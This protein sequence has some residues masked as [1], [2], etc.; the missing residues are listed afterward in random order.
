MTLPEVAP[1]GTGVTMLV[2]AHVVGVASEPLK[3][4]VLLPCG[5][6]KFDPE[7]VSEFPIAP[8]LGEMA[9]ILGDGT[10]VKLMPLLAT[11]LAF[12][13]TFPVVAPAGTTATTLVAIQ[14]LIVALLPLKVRVPLPCVDPKFVPLTVTEAPAAPEVGD[15]LDI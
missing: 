11:P 10:T 1:A 13:T 14:L 15:R 3:L 4:T 12:T 6:P 8:G 5:L 2:A 9:V 7:I